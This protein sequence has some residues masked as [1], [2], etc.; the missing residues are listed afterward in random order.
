MFFLSYVYSRTDF[1]SLL[2]LLLLL[3]YFVLALTFK[4]Y[5]KIFSCLYNFCNEGTQCRVLKH[6]VY[7]YEHDCVQFISVSSLLVSI[8]YVLY[9]GVQFTFSPQIISSII[10][11]MILILYFMTRL[12]CKK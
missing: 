10:P 12:F 3:F 9:M 11:V 4:S 1:L 2:F 7:L 6:F 8:H 5:L